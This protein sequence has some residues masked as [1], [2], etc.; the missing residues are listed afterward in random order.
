[1]DLG[2]SP[3]SYR[4]GSSFLYKIP[5]IFKILFMFVFGTA[6]F[7]FKESQNLILLSIFCFLIVFELCVKIGIKEQ[8]QTFKPIFFIVVL[9]FFTT[10]LN[11]FITKHSFLGIFADYKVFIPTISLILKLLITMQ[12]TSLV[13]KTTTF[14][15]IKQ[16]LTTI[17]LFFRKVLHLHLKTTFSETFAFMM[18]FIPRVFDVYSSLIKACIAREPKGKIHLHNYFGIF[19]EVFALSMHKAYET[20]KAINSRLK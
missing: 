19:F 9:L 1:M 2:I 4:I 10:M 20:S 13:F 8:L 3:F 7:T 11:V 5:P 18:L 16:T 17:E 15:Q 6:I 14:L 12:I